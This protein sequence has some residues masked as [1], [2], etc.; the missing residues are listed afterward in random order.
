MSSEKFESATSISWMREDGILETK[1]KENAQDTIESA[2]ENIQILGELAGEGNRPPLFVDFR[3]IKSQTADARA[4]YA[5]EEAAKCMCAVALMAEGPI[6][7]MVGNFFV[8]LNK[9][10]VPLKLFSNREDAFAWLRTF[11]SGG[12]NGE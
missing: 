1:M 4:Y 3:N 2:K 12:E 9:P 11:Q 5:G 10:K 6:S 8:G 7:R